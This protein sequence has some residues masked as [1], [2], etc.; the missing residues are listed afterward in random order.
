MMDFVL[1]HWDLFALLAVV[2]GLLALTGFA[3]R[4][5]GVKSLTPTEAVQLMNRSR[6]LILDLRPESDF[7]ASHLAQAQHLPPGNLQQAVQGLAS[8]KQEA[9]LLVGPMGGNVGKAAKSLRQAGIEQVYLLR[10]GMTA[11]QEA[12]LPVTRG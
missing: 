5:S 1:R 9:A 2:L 12:N 4:L 6:V 7:A 8:G 11:W 10:G 3:D